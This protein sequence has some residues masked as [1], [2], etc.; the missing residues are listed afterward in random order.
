MIK[1]GKTAGLLVSEN[2]TLITPEFVLSELRKH[3]DEILVMTHRSH[4]DFEKFLL[5]VEDKVEVVPN[6]KIIPFLQRGK[7]HP[8]VTSE[9][10]TIPCF[11]TTERLSDMVGG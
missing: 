7:K 11:R 1:D 6:S 3:K 10:C 2:L 9:R 4:E 5:I 8:S